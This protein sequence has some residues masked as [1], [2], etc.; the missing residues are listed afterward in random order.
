MFHG[1]DSRFSSR[2]TILVTLLYHS[3]SD[4]FSSFAPDISKAR[5]SS[6]NVNRLMERVPQIDSWSGKGKHIE[7]LEQGYLRFRDVHFRYPTR[8][9]V[10]V[11]RGLDFEVKPGQYVALVGSSGCGK[12]TAVALIERFYDPVVGQVL[13]DGMDVQGYNVSDY[14]KNISLVSQ[15]P[16]YLTPGKCI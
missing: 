2:R 10:P 8:P 4:V 1:F 13:V 11:L 16:T 6:A 3:F 14:R 5:S 7:Y 9:H 15:E 12:S